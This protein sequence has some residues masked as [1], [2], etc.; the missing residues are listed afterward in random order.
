[1]IIEKD[2]LLNVSTGWYWA[3]QGDGRPRPIYVSAT[4]HLVALNFGYREEVYIYKDVPQKSDYYD[5]VV[6]CGPIT[7]PEF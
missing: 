1:M 3:R 4:E 5:D 2:D 7:P 6:L